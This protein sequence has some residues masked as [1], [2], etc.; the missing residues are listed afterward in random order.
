MSDKNDTKD[1][2]ARSRIVLTTKLFWG[3]DDINEK[4]LSRKHILEGMDASL[5]RLKLDYVDIVFC[6]RP[7][8]LGNMEETVRGF[9]QL[10][11]DGKAHYW[12]TSEWSAQQITEAYWIAKVHNLIP[13][14]VEQPQYNL[15]HR[16]RVEK[17]YAPLYK[18]PYNI[19]TTI[20]SPLASGVL[21]GKYNKE[22]PKGSRMDAK[23]YEWL[24]KSWGKTKAERVPKVEKLMAIA[25]RLDV[26]V[27]Q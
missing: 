7:D 24:A 27:T 12:G 2:W 19:G 20:W 9:T 18:G 4:G 14:V 10:I 21:T 1:D 25:K 5:K 8:P 23:G 15:F 6:H 22:I 11:K 16:E 17:E 3:G 13:P 26:S